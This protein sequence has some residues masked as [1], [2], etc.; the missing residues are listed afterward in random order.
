MWSL[1]ETLDAEGQLSDQTQDLMGWEAQDN[2]VFL[3]SLLLNS[4]LA[5]PRPCD[6][7]T[8][9]SLLS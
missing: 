7:G 3:S 8:P 2:T 6:V 5:E 4:H 1:D 9:V